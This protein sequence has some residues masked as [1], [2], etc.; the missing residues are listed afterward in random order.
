MVD[1]KILEGAIRLDRG[2]PE[3]ETQGVAIPFHL[4]GKYGGSHG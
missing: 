3:H 1:N 4:K 2:E